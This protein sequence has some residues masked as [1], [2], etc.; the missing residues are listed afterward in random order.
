MPR[1]NRL[2]RIPAVITTIKPTFINSFGSCDF[3][4][5]SMPSRGL[6]YGFG[7]IPPF[8]PPARA[9]RIGGEG[10]AALI[11][12][13]RMTR[14]SVAVTGNGNRQ[15]PVESHHATAM[16]RGARLTTANSVRRE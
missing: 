12:S 16:P 10:P 1:A 9:Y 15:L 8:Y 5:S 3:R 14:N 11:S 13:I 6:S 7:S 4:A 2:S